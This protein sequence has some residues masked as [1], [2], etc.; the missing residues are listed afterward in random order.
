MTAEMVTA[1]AAVCQEPLV[2]PDPAE[3][4]SAHR[5]P[6]RSCRLFL[7]LWLQPEGWQV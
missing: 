1:D 7:A 2:R 5:F 4:R 6:K 3:S